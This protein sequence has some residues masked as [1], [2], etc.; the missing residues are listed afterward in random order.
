[1]LLATYTERENAQNGN[2]TAVNN[3][4]DLHTATWQTFKI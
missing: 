4:D 3:E 1:M 2:C